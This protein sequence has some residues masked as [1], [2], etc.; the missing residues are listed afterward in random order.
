LDVFL[1]LLSSSHIFFFSP[2]ELLVAWHWKGAYWMWNR[3][4][5]ICGDYNKQLHVVSF[6]S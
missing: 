4:S 2:V 5:V 1:V 6:F 3:D